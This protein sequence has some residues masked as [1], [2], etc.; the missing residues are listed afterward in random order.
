[1]ERSSARSAR[2]QNNSNRN[3][4]SNKTDVVDGSYGFEEDR[5]DTDD[6]DKPKPLYSDNMVGGRRDRDDYRD[7]ERGYG[8]EDNRGGRGGARGRGYR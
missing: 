4:N 1:M 2:P 5:M 8:R 7:K 3:R 6:Y